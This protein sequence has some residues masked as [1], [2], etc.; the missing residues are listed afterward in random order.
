MACVALPV[1]SGQHRLR[2]IAV[3]G[4]PHQAIHTLLIQCLQDIFELL[5]DRRILI[6]CVLEAFEDAW[7]DHA[8]RF[9]VCHRFPTE[10]RD[11]SRKKEGD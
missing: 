2:S 11:T 4:H 8:E 9:R 1:G 6:D 10:R 5:P 3:A 7:I